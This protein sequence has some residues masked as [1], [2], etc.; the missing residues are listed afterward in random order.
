MS[1][2]LGEHRKNIEERLKAM[3]P[4]WSQELEIGFVHDLRKLL[5]ENPSIGFF[6]SP[7]SNILVD[8]SGDYSKVSDWGFFAITTSKLNQEALDNIRYL[9]EYPCGQT[10]KYKRVK[11]KP[12]FYKDIS[13]QT[14][15]FIPVFT[16]RLY[17]ESFSSEPKHS[18]D[19][20]LCFDKD[21]FQ[22]FEKYSILEVDYLIREDE[23]SERLITREDFIA[24]RLNS[25]LMKGVPKEVT[26]NLKSCLSYRFKSNDT[27][28]EGIR[29]K[30]IGSFA[31]DYTYEN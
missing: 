28:Q 9:C 11:L 10:E 14:K 31:P 27:R 2:E 20:I 19:G 25:F 8:T 24:S 16:R 6:P 22:N 5:Q 17:N 13:Y 3:N 23:L 7:N 4:F 21:A 30:V 29:D 18:E 12:D 1:F 26:D 15:T